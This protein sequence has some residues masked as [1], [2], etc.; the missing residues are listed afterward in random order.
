LSEKKKFSEKKMNGHRYGKC[1]LPAT[2]SEFW[3]SFSIFQTSPVF[4]NPFI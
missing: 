3:K 2:A 1:I 4:I